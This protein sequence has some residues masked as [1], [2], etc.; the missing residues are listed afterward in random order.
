MN[1]VCNSTKM[2]TPEKIAGTKHGASPPLQKVG[3]HVP[4][5]PTD[6]YAHAASACVSVILWRLGTTVI[7]GTGTMLV[8]SVG[9]NSTKGVVFNLLDVTGNSV[10]IKS[11]L[12]SMR[13]LN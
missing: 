11:G 3:R 1:T 12:I 7:E 2:S 10:S 13:E 4:C 8:T 6:L 9:V 5:P